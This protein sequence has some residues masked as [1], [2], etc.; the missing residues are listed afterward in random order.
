MEPSLTQ[1]G[2][3]NPFLHEQELVQLFFRPGQ[4]QLH[5]LFKTS[6]EKTAGVVV[7]DFDS[8]KVKI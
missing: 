6:L 5:F 1:S 2:D 4:K 8:L 3:L 7:C